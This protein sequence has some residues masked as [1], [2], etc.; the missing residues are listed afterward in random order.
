MDSGYVKKFIVVILFIPGFLV[1]CFSPPIPN[2]E[3]AIQ[4]ADPTVIVPL[5]NEVEGAYF[6][7]SLPFVP[8]PT[9]GLVAGRIRNRADINQLETSLMRLATD[10]FDSDVVFIREGQYLSSDFVTQILRVLN[11]EPV[12]IFESI[13]GLNPPLG[14]ELIFSNQT[15]ESNAANPIR[16][17]TFIIE[18]NFVTIK[19]DALES[20][21]NLEG[22]ALGL[23]IN[24][25]HWVVDQS[26]GHEASYRMSDEDALA[27]GQEIALRLLPIIRT[28][29]GLEDVSILFGI[30][31]LRSYREVIPGNFVATTF[32]DVGENHIASWRP[33]HERF[34]ELPDRTNRIHNYDVNISEEFQSFINIIDTHFP[35]Q[36]HAIARVHIVERQVYELSVDFNMS[37]L[38]ASELI[39]FHQL[40]EEQ[41]ANFSNG[42]RIKVITQGLGTLHGVVTRG[43][44]GH[45]QTTLI[46]W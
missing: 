17:F 1:G 37:F 44:S 33:A 34:I 12:E 41:L 23:A 8:S 36:H 27:A 19:E 14:S 21:F 10:Y 7:T 42:Y 16:P 46:D 4:N 38:G 15:F 45:I 2:I 29:E 11:E 43:L 18:H 35:H 40:I 26:I 30:Y 13:I 20:R 32:I 39:A 25:Y 9:R 28:I 31:I 24:P 6:R 3:Q 22:V 5:T